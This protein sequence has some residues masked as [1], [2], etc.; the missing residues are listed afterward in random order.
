MT[1]YFHF[2]D[3]INHVP[4]L[5]WL[6]EISDTNLWPTSIQET[7]THDRYLETLCADLNAGCVCVCVCHKHTSLTLFEK[8]RLWKELMS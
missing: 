6:P 2:I 5:C 1:I 8:E 3:S 7:R 4:F